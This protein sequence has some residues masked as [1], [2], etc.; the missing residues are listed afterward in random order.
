MIGL[1]TNVLAR[2]FVEEANADAAT[3]VQRLAA[4][5]R[6]AGWRYQ[7]GRLEPDK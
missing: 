6:G 5:R 3:A 7:R 1:D 2:Y 4:R